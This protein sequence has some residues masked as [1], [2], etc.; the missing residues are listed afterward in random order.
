VRPFAEFPEHHIHVVPVRECLPASAP[1]LRFVFAG[2]LLPRLSVAAVG[3]G[4][5]SS[6]R[7]GGEGHADGTLWAFEFP[8]KIA[9]LRVGVSKTDV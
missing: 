8:L 9:A 6:S 4:G 1:L 5:C 2:R 7:R 3:V